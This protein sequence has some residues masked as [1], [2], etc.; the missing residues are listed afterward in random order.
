M[1]RI[2]SVLLALLLAAGVSG[3]VVQGSVRDG[4]GEAL[5][6]AG[7]YVK[8]ST[9]GTSTTRNGSYTLTLNPGTYVLVF[10]YV[11]FDSTER[12]VRLARG[13]QLRLDVSLVRA[14]TQIGTAEVVADTR[15]KAKEI[16]R[17]VRDRRPAYLDAVQT[18]ACETYHRSTL[19]REPKNYQPIAATG[20][21]PELL[22]SAGIEVDEPEFLL[23]REL[24][25]NTQF[26]AASRYQEHITAIQK[27][28]EGDIPEEPMRSMS[29]SGGNSF[30][31][32]QLVPWAREARNEYLVFE[33]LLSC[34]FNFYENTF[35][36]DAIAQRQLTS[37][38]AAGS[39]LLYRY[40]YA[41]AVYEAGRMVHKLRVT[42]LSKG[43]P[44]FEGTLFVADSSFALVA[45]DL[46]IN[47][48]AMTLCKDF[49]IVQ[50]YDEIAP[51]IWLPVRRELTY[52]IGEGSNDIVGRATLEHT[53]YVI[54]QPLPQAF[55]PTE[56][57][58]YDPKAF[59]RDT[60]YWQAQRPA[61]LNPDDLIFM[62]HADSVRN[63]LQSDEWLQ[64]QDSV[65]NVIDIWTPLVGYGY[66]NRAKGVELY[67]EGLLGQINPFGIGG[68]RHRL[69]AQVSLELKGGYT[70]ETNGFVDYGFANNDIKGRISAGLTY[71]PLKFVRTM[72]TFG[73]YYEMVNDYASIEQIFSRSNFIRTT[74]YGISQRQELI[75]GLFAEASFTFEDQRALVGLQLADWSSELFG[76]LNTPLD[77]ARYKKSEFRLRMQ[78]NIRQRYEIKRGRKLILGSDYPELYLEYRKGVPGLFGSEVNF[79]YLE[80]GASHELDLVRYGSSRWQVQMGTYLNKANLRILEYK[81]FRG[82][83]QYFFSDPLRSFQLL[84]PTLNTPNEWFQ[85]SY[86]HHFEGTLLGKVPLINR[87][88][89]Q[90]AAGG[91][92]LSIPDSGFNHGE[93][94]AGLER[95]FRIKGQ[96][97]RFGAY[98]VTADNTL[99]GPNLTY[100]FGFAFY[101][102][103][104]RKWDY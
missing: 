41:G 7:V 95:N 32:A 53:G 19:M 6:F 63:Y 79:D 47:R 20:L 78:Y 103:F 13:E 18:Y 96:L 70:L 61:V 22:D 60:T 38:I 21:S 81:Y 59:D 50:N 57:R 98:A 12:E 16:M 48:A 68:Y 74:E 66:R 3:Q 24:V 45:V 11:G 72:L 30:G 42:P 64:R 58:R 75:N 33:D 89:L 14:A 27:F 91:G 31:D 85:A 10:S 82:S 94:F 71:R 44:L 90:L 2:A 97:F 88:K 51:G 100:K 39:A 69:P 9:Y 102:S 80:I 34:G 4:A 56:V 54:N 65:Y 23:M 49:H 67:I 35:P 36:Y 43:E 83:D 77:F 1:N 52:H 40:D 99:A 93:L 5:P 37:P 104:R 15:D 101:D 25:S 26:R 8:D 92:V 28:K 84:G 87:L 29:A 55:S 17:N 76:D 46:R 62:Q 86:I 73:D